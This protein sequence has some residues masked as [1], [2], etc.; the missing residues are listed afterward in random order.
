MAYALFMTTRRL[1]IALDLANMTAR[2]HLNVRNGNTRWCYPA[3]CLQYI[4]LLASLWTQ[5][6]IKK[7][8]NQYKL[9]T[10]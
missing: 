9:L 2:C 5:A 3:Q 7:T 6:E 4:L 10:I 8:S 1:H